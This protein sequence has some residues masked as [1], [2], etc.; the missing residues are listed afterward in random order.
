M[1]V[2]RAW[3]KEATGWVQSREEEVGN[4]GEIGNIL[5]HAEGVV[6]WARREARR[7]RVGDS[8]EEVRSCHEGGDEGM[9][10]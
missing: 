10:S 4:E 2:G 5:G 9:L 6:G 3:R 7:E 1:A 8:E